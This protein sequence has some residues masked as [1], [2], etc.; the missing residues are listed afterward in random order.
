M[1][2]RWLSNKS[3]FSDRSWAQD[4]VF[5]RSPNKGVRQISAWRMDSCRKTL[6]ICTLFN[7]NN[8]FYSFSLTTKR[9]R[10]QQK[11]RC[12]DEEEE[13]NRGRDQQTIKTKKKYTY[14]RR[15][16]RLRQSFGRGTH[17]GGEGG[18]GRRLH[19]QRRGRGK[20]VATEEERRK[21]EE[22]RRKK[23]KRRRRR[24]WRKKKKEEEER[25]SLDKD[26]GRRKI[27]KEERKERLGMAMKPVL[28]GIRP[29]PSR[30][31]WGIP[32]LTRYR[33]KFGFR[34]YSTFLI[35]V[36][37]QGCHYPSHTHS[38]IRPDDEIIKIL[39]ITCYFFF[40]NFYII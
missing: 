4:L 26:R 33:Y 38:R 35:G 15:G 30:C 13:T 29:N 18:G 22:G 6:K 5:I 25:K 17:G 39:L 3:N 32:K 23:M 27:E 36:G 34:G 14:W 11:K 37:G 21:K 24:P 7:K 28:M 20:V 9:G 8:F 1:W 40:Y 12:N 16:R 10:D 2:E 19:L 31:W